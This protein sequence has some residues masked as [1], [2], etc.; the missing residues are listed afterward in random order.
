MTRAERWATVGIFVLP[1]LFAANMLSAR[2]AA[3]WLPPVALATG[4]WSMTFL[5]LLPLALPGIAL[6]R[7]ALRHEW[8]TLLLLGALGMGLCGAP[9]YIAGHTTTGTN[10]GLI[11]AA[12]PILMVLLDRIGWGQAIRPRQI[13]GI[14]LAL[15]GV[16][17][18][19]AKGDPQNLLGLYFT[20]G[21]LWVV[22]AMSSWALYSVLLRH[23]PSAFALPARFALICGFGVLANLPFLALEMA[24]GE[25][26][27]M[28][29][30][31]L[32]M[33][34]FL[35][36]FASVGAFLLHA[37]VQSVLGVGRTGVF[38]YLGPVY[39]TALAW[40]LLGEA[41][42]IFHLAGLALVLP[43]VWLAATPGRAPAHPTSPGTS[44]R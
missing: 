12:S 37:K 1:V 36:V 40:A 6:A 39:N 2:W 43:G 20:V 5:L 13:L 27:P 33:V 31:A 34:I 38:L 42:Q 4:R 23:R 9:V 11:Y 28:T 44:A 15:A 41:P 19:L 3:G 22:G 16:L 29:W 8:P 14:L 24:A 21:D 26:M 25:T 7:R 30:R 17:A 32:G 10:I 35:A 18:I